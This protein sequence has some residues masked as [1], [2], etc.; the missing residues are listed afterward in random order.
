MVR[1]EQTRSAKDEIL[2]ADQRRVCFHYPEAA[3]VPREIR[4]QAPFLKGEILKT[5]PLR[6]D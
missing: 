2:C 6:I 3:R 1:L 4:V 5:T